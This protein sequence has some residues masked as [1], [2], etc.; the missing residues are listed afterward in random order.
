MVGES[1][2]EGN[3]V[4][5]IGMDL[6]MV[7]K[8]PGPQPAQLRRPRSPVAFPGRRKGHATKAVAKKRWKNPK[9]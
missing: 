1:W 9:G 3:L 8:A 5:A 7:P 2:L 4:D 6:G